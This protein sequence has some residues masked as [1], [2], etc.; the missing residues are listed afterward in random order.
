M[1][2][3]T[4][5]WTLYFQALDWLWLCL[6]LFALGLAG[7]AVLRPTAAPRH[8]A[9]PRHGPA[10]LRRAALAAL[11]AGVPLLLGA[12]QAGYHDCLQNRFDSGVMANLAWNLVHGN[13]MAASILAD[14]SYFAVH[15]A[16]FKMAFAPLLL[17][18]NSA[19]VLAM[20][21]GAA[22]G[23]S[24]PALYLL[25]RRRPG[26]EQ[27]AWVF[28]LLGLANPLFHE[29]SVTVLDNI[30]YAVPLFLWAAYFAESGR[31]VPALGLGLL[32]LTTREEAPFLAFG[33]GAFLWMKGGR[34]RLASAV[35]AGSVALFIGEMALITSMRE[36]WGGCR[37]YWG[38]FFQGLGASAS[39]AAA[40]PWRVVG[41][42]FLPSEKLLTPVK[43]LASLGFLPLLSPTT[44][45]LALPAW[46][47]HQ[48]ADAGT[49]YHL[50]TMHYSA[51]LLGPLLWSS[52]SGF[53]WLR[54]RLKP[55]HQGLPAAGLLCLAGALFLSADRFHR[56]G[57]V[58]PEWPSSAEAALRHIP[59]DAKVWA[60]QFFLPKLAL[61]RHLR[62]IPPSLPDCFFEPGLFLPDRVLV[63]AHW[64]S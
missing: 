57:F 10:I 42:L 39:E 3:G 46:V 58:P 7:A 47:P 6:G 40:A 2:S 60:D 53:E 8:A 21:Q 14:R 64:L 29:L 27:A 56:P 17:T 34:R 12:L 51:L 32:L 23:S 20:V 37:D 26:T 33:L 44:L 62:G 50:L 55:V 18:W 16:F 45:L 13:G 25:A 48:A 54:A 22:L 59:D 24:I 36:G 43:V 4:P 19:G 49:S 9:V 38:M 41:A 35:M 30:V 1:D 31:L 61:R 5:A 11:A 63:T 15:F 28:A 52:L